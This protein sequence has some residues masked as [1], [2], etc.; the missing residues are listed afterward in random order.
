MK[1]FLGIDTATVNCGMTI[2]DYN[3]NVLSSST[4]VVPAWARDNISCLIYL[5]EAIKKIINAISSKGHTLEYAILES[6]A[7]AGFNGFSVGF[8][9]GSLTSTLASM[10]IPF[11]WVAPVQ[12]K[13]FATGA[14]KA[15]KKLMINSAVEFV[16]NNSISYPKDFISKMLADSNMADSFHMARIA[17]E[18]YKQIVQLD[19]K[20]DKFVEQ[21]KLKKIRDYV[22]QNKITK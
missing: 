10:N 18:R 2:L 15:D 9:L 21:D 4:I 19:I 17:V 13:K 11:G 20:E 22:W 7:F 1:C 14:G 3:N 12:V 16:N 5:S 6:P 8:V